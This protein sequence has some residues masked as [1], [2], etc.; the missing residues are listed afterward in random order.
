M[1]TLIVFLGNPERTA[2]ECSAALQTAEA[3]WTHFKDVWIIRSTKGADWWAQ[4]LRMIADND[5]FHFLV[6]EAKIKNY[7]GVVPIAFFDWM[8]ENKI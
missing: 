5:D 4:R 3:C 2:R 7:D 6:V 1:K 8:L